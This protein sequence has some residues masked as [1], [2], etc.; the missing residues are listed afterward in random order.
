MPGKCF[1]IRQE[2]RRTL[3]LILA[4]ATAGL[5]LVTVFALSARLWW[6]FDLFSHFRLQYLVLAVALC[7][8]ALAVRAFPTAAVLALIALVHA[9][10]I[11]DLG[12]SG[13]AAAGRV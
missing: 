7:L 5:A 6:A 12:L 8:V 13:S 9:W 3:K 2:W 1:V 10:A 4:A 11:K